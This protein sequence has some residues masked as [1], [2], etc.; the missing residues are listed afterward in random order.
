[1]VNHV[2]VVVVVVVVDGGGDDVERTGLTGATVSRGLDGR[3]EADVPA[4]DLA[5]RLDGQLES[6]QDVDLSRCRELIGVVTAVAA[7]RVDR[8]RL[9]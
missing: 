5:N 1:M 9:Q 6:A 4:D 8:Y 7:R 3:A 2:V